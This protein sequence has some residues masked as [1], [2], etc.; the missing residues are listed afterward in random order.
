MVFPNS[1][2]FTHLQEDGATISD[3]LVFWGLPARAQRLG[4]FIQAGGVVGRMKLA[5]LK[6]ISPE[7]AARAAVPAPAIPRAL[8]SAEKD[9]FRDRFRALKRAFG[10]ESAH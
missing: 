10:I 1:S 7:V 6:V 9:D 8:S 2:G 4:D 5:K 3:N